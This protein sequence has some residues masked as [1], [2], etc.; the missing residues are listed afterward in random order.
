MS[1]RV[2]VRVPV[3]LGL[4]VTFMTQLAPAL[5]VAGGVPQV[6]LDTVK[7]LALVPVML[8]DKLMSVPVPVLETDSAFV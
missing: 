2:A 7:S 3:A 5:S 1:L 4:K 6:V 8:Q